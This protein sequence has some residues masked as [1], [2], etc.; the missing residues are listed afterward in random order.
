MFDILLVEDDEKIR[1]IISYFYKENGE[2]EFKITEACSGEECLKKIYEKQFDLILLDIMLPGVN[3]LEVCEEIRKNNDVPIIFITARSLEE[4]VLRGYRYGCDDYIIKPFMMSE[5]YVKVKALIN[6][7][8]GMVVKQSMQVGNILLDSFSNKVQMNGEEI[9]LAH[10]EF[11]I[12]KKLMENKNRTVSR[13]GLLTAVW[14]YDFEG[15]E[16]ALDDHIR[17]LRKAL[18]AESILIKTVI[19]FGYKISDDGEKD[20]L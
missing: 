4:D 16:R 13:E 15:N 20:E 1:E 8:K 14:G 2:H 17:K 18:G 12:L 10:I 6:R 19:H 9:K 5:L 3:G 11:E 7:S